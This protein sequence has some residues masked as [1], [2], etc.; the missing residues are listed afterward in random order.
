MILALPV[1]SK[2]GYMFKLL[3]DIA[4]YTAV[5]FWKAIQ[6]NK[7]KTSVLKDKRTRL[8]AEALFSVSAKTI[9]GK[10]KCPSLVHDTTSIL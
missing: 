3:T 10:V 4:F 6:K 7:N 2:S 5:S 9:E 8:F 1:T